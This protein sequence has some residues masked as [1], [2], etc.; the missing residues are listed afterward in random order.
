M[1]RPIRVAENP[2]RISE[3]RGRVRRE[4]PFR[5]TPRIPRWVDADP[6]VGRLDCA[7]VDRSRHRRSGGGARLDGDAGTRLG[8][9]ERGS[10]PPLGQPPRKGLSGTTGGVFCSLDGVPPASGPPEGSE[11]PRGPNVVFRGGVTFGVGVDFQAGDMCHRRTSVCAHEQV[12][13]ASSEGV[14]LPHPFGDV[15]R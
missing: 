15:A 8:D 3:S 13:G 1:L 9:V 4:P 7:R 10:A 11:G 2:R 14:A 12:T 5:G 6:W